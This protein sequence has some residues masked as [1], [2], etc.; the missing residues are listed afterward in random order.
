MDA[1]LILFRREDTWVPGCTLYYDED[2]VQER[3]D[4]Y[5]SSGETVLIVKVQACQ[6][7]CKCGVSSRIV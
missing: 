4:T 2:E 1:W 6:G 3:A 5:S 7:H